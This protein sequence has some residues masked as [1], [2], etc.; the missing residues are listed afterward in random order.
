MAWL[1]Q[2]QTSS[3]RKGK[4]FFGTLSYF[5]KADDAF[6]YSENVRKIVVYSEE[7]ISFDCLGKR[8]KLATKEELNKFNFDKILKEEEKDVYPKPFIRNLDA[9]IEKLKGCY[10][11]YNSGKVDKFKVTV[12]FAQWKIAIE[13]QLN[14]E[15][16]SMY[17]EI[18]GE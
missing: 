12:A 8:F 13:K 10:G 4:F 2:Y 5:A 15:L 14:A 3:H 16:E 1:V 6:N 11:L 18:K 17:N 9:H 7:Q